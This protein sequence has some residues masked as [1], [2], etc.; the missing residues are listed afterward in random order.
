LRRYILGLSLFE[1]FAYTDYS[2]RSGCELFPVGKPAVSLLPERDAQE[3]DVDEV[4]KY[5]KQAATDFG[6]ST[7]PKKF[8]FKEAL[9]RGIAEKIVAERA[10]KAAKKEAR[11]AKKKAKKEAAKAKA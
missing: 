11:E 3:F 4:Y 5:A 10:E 2:L 9:L 8:T 1:V 7:E 6:V